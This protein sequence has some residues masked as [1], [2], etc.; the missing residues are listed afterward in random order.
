MNKY[1]IFWGE[2]HN[3]THHSAGQKVSFGDILDCAAT[4][5]DFYAA[6]YYTAWAEAF[7]GEGHL[8]ESERRHKIVLEGWKPQEQI[9]REWAEVCTLTRAR[10]TPGRFVT[11]PGYEWQGD[12][13]SG[14]H[15]VIMRE[16]GLPVFRVQKLAELYNRLRGHDALAIPHHTAYRPGMRGRDWSVFDEELSPFCEIYSIHGCSETDEEWIGLRHNSH[17]GPGFGDGTW[18]TALDRGYHIGA[19]CSSDGWRDMPGPHGYGLMACLAEECT[20][21]SLWRA[22]RARRVYGVTGDRIALDFRVNEA[23]MGEVVPVRGKRRITVRVSGLDALDR[24]ELLRNGRVIATHCHQGTWDLPSPGRR[25]RFRVR[26]EAGWGPRPNELPIQVREWRGT[27]RVAGGRVLAWWP[28]WI[29]PGQ[30]IPLLHG[31]TAEFTFKTSTAYVQW[32]RQNA[33]VFEFE[34]E[35]NAEMCVALNGLETRGAVS[36]FARCSR[37]LWYKDDCIRML[38]ELAGVAPGTPERMDV[39]HHCAFKVKIH[40]PIPESGYSATWEVEDDSPITAGEV[41][42]RVRVEQR[43]AQRAWSSPIWVRPVC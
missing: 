7:A 11:F 4:H 25:S 9:E 37:E 20:R 31:D 1:Q 26:I 34:A 3:N 2:T 22:F 17:M 14:D 8:S 19:I 10:Y 40:R 13:T 18:Q 35:P 15:N 43:N 30:G 32:P 33:T 24:I 27:L 5:L 39:Y 16:E 12:G 23:L 41:H 6:A 28:C 21:E 36:D 38:H 29:S 42:Y